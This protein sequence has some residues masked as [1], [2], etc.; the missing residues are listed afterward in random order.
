MK[1]IRNLWDVKDGDINISEFEVFC[2]WSINFCEAAK[3]D[4]KTFNLEK[5]ISSLQ[6]KQELAEQHMTRYAKIFADQEQYQF[7]RFFTQAKD[8]ISYREK[9][10]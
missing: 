6:L 5:E 7:S 2:E 8:N 3:I 10:L 1:R 9:A 4:L